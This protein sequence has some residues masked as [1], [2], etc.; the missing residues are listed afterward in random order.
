[1]EILIGRVGKFGILINIPRSAKTAFHIG[2]SN[3]GHAGNLAAGISGIAANNGIGHRC[4]RRS[5]VQ[6]QSAAGTAG[7]RIIIN[8]IVKHGNIGTGK[9]AEAAAAET[10]GIII[11]NDIILQDWFS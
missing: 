9:Q 5:A 4:K 8:K 1:M 10:I 11:N 3:V 6:E 7:A 2:I